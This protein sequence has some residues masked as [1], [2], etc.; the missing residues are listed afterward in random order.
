[1]KIGLISHY[2]ILFFWAS[3]LL[4]QKEG[5]TWV[6]GYYGKGDPDYSVMHLNFSEDNINI[7]WHFDETMYITESSSTISTQSGDALIWTNGMQIF[8][9][10]GQYICDTISYGGFRSSYWDWY[11]TETYGP[12]GFPLHS[13]TLILPIPES[14]YQYLV[15]YHTAE[16]NDELYFQV[17]QFLQAKISVE[18][19]TSFTVHYK[20]SLL[21]PYYKWYD[22]DIIATRHANGRDWWI[23]LFEANSTTYHSFLLAPDGASL[24]H[25]GEIESPIKFGL[26]QSVFSPLG[27]FIAKVNAITLEEGQ[28]ITLLE[29][30]RCEG[31]LTL[32]STFH[33]EAGYF[34]GAAFSPSD[35]FL[36]ADDNHHL[37]QWDLTA[38]DIAASQIL[39]D[40]FDGFV[41]PG[42]FPMR[43]GPMMQT[44]D[45]RIYIVPPAGSS[46]F[47][48][49]IDRPD[50]PGKECRFLQHHVN[51]TKPNGR[52]APN[53]PNFRL[54]P[55]DGS[56]CDT[57]GIDNL[58]VARW[59]FE[60]N[61]PGYWYDIFFTDMSFY[62]PRTWH[63]DFDDG[64][65]SNEQHT[66]HTFSP[67]LYHV[68]LTVSNDFGSDSLCRWVNV[69]ATETSDPIAPSRDLSI[70][71]NP[72]RDALVIHSK[73]GVIRP[74]HMQLFDIYGRLVFDQPRA[75]VPVTIYLPDRIGPGIYYCRIREEDG[76][77]LEF[78]LVKTQ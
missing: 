21:G 45:D 74:V 8:G 67:G 36:Y 78:N 10:G 60:E 59:R 46:E 42:W 66:L 63:W 39:I 76:T 44:P 27:N 48:H 52:S 65:T 31:I 54:G 43:F 2:L 24:K 23:I 55:L 40:T 75:P 68:C 5:D 61:Y 47:M 32:N 41:Q 6:I 13:S 70:D 49:V 34:T 7:N 35:Q 71:P 33:T 3:T 53:I 16:I 56:V 29:F 30:D 57:L 62:D 64:T 1:M 38:D 77:L 4:A 51:L 20:D 28:Y 18:I 12:N 25:T 73:S 72:F 26:G 14:Q 19:D 69:I 17:S 37:W 15:L 22:G 50:M 9:Q 11:T 58:P